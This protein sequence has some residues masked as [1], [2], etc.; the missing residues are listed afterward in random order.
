MTPK[1]ITFFLTS[2]R[3]F[4]TSRKPSWVFFLITFLCFLI[5][6]PHFKT[7]YAIPSSDRAEDDDAF[8]FTDFGAGEGSRN[9]EFWVHCIVLILVPWFTIFVLNVLIIGKVGTVNRRMTSVKSDKSKEKT[10]RAENQLTKLLLTVTFTFLVLIAFQCI[11]QC[12]YMLQ[13]KSVGLK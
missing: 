1:Y 8:A 12:F 9:Y 4:A 7:Y 13:P 3:I 5:N 2:Y 10:R 6:I 11:T